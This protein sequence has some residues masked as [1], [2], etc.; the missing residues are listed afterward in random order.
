MARAGHVVGGKY[1]LIHPLGI[2]GMGMVWRAEHES[3]KQHVALKLLH[4]SGPQAERT[5]RR[6]QREAQI[7]ASIRHRNIVYI[8]DFGTNR[9]EPYIVMELLNGVPLAER[10]VV[11]EPLSVAVFLNLMEETLQGLSAVHAAG[12]VHRDMKPENIFLVRESDG[13]VFPKLLDFGV[14]RSTERDLGHTITREGMVMGTPEYISPEQARG[15][16]A[17]LRSD[18]YG[19]GVVIYEALAG[20]LPFQA[21]NPGDLIVALLN[22]TP[23]ELSTLRPELGRELSD[24]VARAMNR[25]PDKRYQSSE[26]MRAAL[27]AFMASGHRALGLSLPKRFHAPPQ[28]QPVDS[29]PS[30]ESEEVA[31]QVLESP[32]IEKKLVAAPTDV[33]PIPPTPRANTRWMAMAGAAAVAL[34]LG[35]SLSASRTPGQRLQ[36]TPPSVQAAAARM[37]LEVTVELE[38]VPADA[39]IV[40]DGIPVQGTTLHFATDSGSHQIEVDAPGRLPFRLVHNAAHGARYTVTMQPEPKPVVQKPRPVKK[41]S[42]RGGL[43]RTPDF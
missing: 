22:Q 6:F 29:H 43:L 14:S 2:G 13:S 4:V 38:R 9:S 37:P 33:I 23:I 26:E 20:R 25:D 15:K 41:A 34:G 27:T 24:F 31:T 16:H 36:L 19:L 17:D 7:A 39:S 11:G 32:I 10:M 1:R 5:F 3:L 18:I 35:L 21:D 12:V 8:S 40:V 28:V 30:Y 42:K